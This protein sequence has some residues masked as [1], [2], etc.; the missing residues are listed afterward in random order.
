M[1]LENTFND[2]QKGLELVEIGQHNEALAHIQRHL[3]G[4]PDNPEVLNDAGALLHCL[5]RS[6]E[7]IDYFVKA[8][9]LNSRSGEILWNLVEAYLAVG[10]DS[11]AIR[12]FDD[13][14]QLGILN[15][16]IINRT[17]TSLLNQNDKA[18]AIEILLRSLSKWPDQKV[19]EPMLEVIRHK[20]PKIAF[21]DGGDGMTFLNDI[22][23]FTKQRFQVRFFEGQT[24]EEMHELMKWSDISWF[25]WC[26]NT[27][28]A[29]SRLPKVCKTIIRLHRYEVH[30]QWPSQ[31]NWDNVDT[32]ITVGNPVVTERL[33]Q[34]I[35]NI[36]QKTSMVTIPNG[37]NFDKYTFIN[38]Q[39]DK[40]I[41]F[42]GNLRMVKNP[43]FLLQC[44]Q[45][46]NYIDPEYKLFIAGN[47]QEPA[48]EQYLKHMNM[49]LRLENVVFFD[50]WQHDVNSW[51]ANKNFIVST[52]IIEGMPM[53][54][55]EAM[56]CGL[57]PIIH[58]FPGAASI[59]PDEF[60]F[61]IAE[62]FCE[63]VISDDYEPR[64]YRRFVEQNFSLNEQ[65]SKIN[66]IFAGFET[67]IDSKFSDYTT[68]IDLSTE[69]AIPAVD[70]VPV[71][72]ANRR[73]ES[74]PVF[75]KDLI[76]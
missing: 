16:D 65:L 24:Q 27:A 67:E 8:R 5:G 12:L 43:A 34:N 42:L 71:I 72:E 26:T 69:F 58:N 29:A 3:L 22:A 76:N 56:A 70:R 35:P 59:Y 73:S 30:G 66:N 23:D 21:F 28:V 45:K 19:I 17:A 4:D 41:A 36:E 25:E 1:T 54:I 37:V 46:L 68:N 51:L 64:K 2:H 15:P 49:A 57:K 10:K 44:M 62:E 48:L 52:S 40:N 9:S 7:A 74:M 55:M 11:E 39:K 63:M 47:F 53:N 31:V 33:K 13:M 60:L 18:N 6:E 61:N 20:R 14:E 38:R 50:G 75:D 32:L